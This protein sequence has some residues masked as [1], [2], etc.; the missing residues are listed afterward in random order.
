MPITNNLGRKKAQL[1][2]E[3]FCQIEQIFVKD[4][5]RNRHRETSSMKW[6]KDR[7][8][9][10]KWSQG[11]TLTVKNQIW[12]ISIQ[13]QIWWIGWWFTIRDWLIQIWVLCRETRFKL[14]RTNN[15]QPTRF[16]LRIF[17]VTIRCR[18]ITVFQREIVSK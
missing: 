9:N 11:Q 13:A 8:S 5:L 10:N 4:S 16:T 12:S 6:S 1:M 15:Q 17:Y 7:S 3:S 2:W 18:H 14:T